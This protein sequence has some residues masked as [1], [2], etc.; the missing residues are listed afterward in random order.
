[1]STIDRQP[2]SFD[3]AIWSVAAALGGAVVSLT[4]SG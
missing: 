2:A 1:M 3:P 4:L